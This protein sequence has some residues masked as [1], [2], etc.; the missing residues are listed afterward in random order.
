MAEGGVL[1]VKLSRAHSDDGYFNAINRE[2]ALSSFILQW[3]VV[4]V[5]RCSV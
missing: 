3:Q 4:L 5:R 2:G 1:E